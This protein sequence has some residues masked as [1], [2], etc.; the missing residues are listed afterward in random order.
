MIII[1]LL[2]A[3]LNIGGIMLFRNNKKILLGLCI[4]PIF[5]LAI[6]GAYIVIGKI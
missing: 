2:I 3:L 4:V 6:I 1:I 5:L